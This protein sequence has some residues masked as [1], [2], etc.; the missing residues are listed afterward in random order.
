MTDQTETQKERSNERQSLDRRFDPSMFDAYAPAAIAKRIETLG[1]TKARMST[2]PVLTL[3]VLAGAF[4]SFGAMFYSLVIT[5][6][7]LGFG[8]GRLVG[9]LSFCLGLVLVV[10]GGAELF[11]GNVLIVM[12]WAHRRVSAGDLGRNWA[13][14]YTGNLIGALAMAIMANWSGFMHLGGDAVGATAIKIAVAKVNLP[15]DVAFIRGVL[16]NALVCLAIWLCFAARSVTD[17]I[18]AILFPITAFV[19]LG[20]E[21]S[22]A[23]MYFIPVGILAAADPGFAEVAGITEVAVT[24]LGASGFI[25]NLIPVT[26]GNIVGG[27]VFVAFSY[28]FVYLRNGE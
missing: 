11:T 13:L 24:N 5:N 10:V 28:Y 15:F 9:G 17:K 3:A 22:I 27:E 18:L 25:S 26:L 14:V 7:E 1:L 2:I 4:I 12:G 8:T 21:H 23:N 19:A 6:S 16:C 20:F